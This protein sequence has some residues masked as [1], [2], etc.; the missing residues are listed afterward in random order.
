MRKEWLQQKKNPGGWMCAQRRMTAALSKLIRLYREAAEG[1][2]FE[3]SSVFPDYLILG[4]DDTSVDLR[5]ISEKLCRRPK[6]RVQHQEQ[7]L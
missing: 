1:A 5:Y 2:G 6:E 7:K 4:D 3:P